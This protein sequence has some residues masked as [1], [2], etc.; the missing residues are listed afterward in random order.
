MCR[1]SSCYCRGMDGLACPDCGGPLERLEEEG[2]SGGARC[3]LCGWAV[4]TTML[5]GILRDQ[6]RYEI[7]VRAAEP[8][9]HAQLRALAGAMGQGLGEVRAS[10]EAG[11]DLAPFSGT[12]VEVARV[13]DVFRGCGL[14]F[15]ILPPFPW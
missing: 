3:S 8:G 9:N 14:V 6:T 12:A 4:A 13:R 11:G 1:R 10:L 7:R 5:P 2:P 15:E